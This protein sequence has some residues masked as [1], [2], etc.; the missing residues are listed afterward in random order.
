MS[1]ARKTA[2][3][4][5][6]ARGIGLGIAERLAA[7][8]A[9]IALVDLNP[10]PLAEAASRFAPEK[11][12][13]IAA[14]VT[15]RQQIINAIDQ[16]AERLGG[17]DIMVNNAGIAQVQPIAEITE[18]EMDRVFAVNVKGVLWGIQAA[19]ARFKKDGTRGKIISA[20]SIATHEGFPMLGAN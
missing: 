15:D 8:G 14:D 19:A 3:V 4:T 6:G 12:I 16:T 5:G 18:A 17:F 1:L 11:V 9:K 13:T 10:G 20:A 2:L 7:D